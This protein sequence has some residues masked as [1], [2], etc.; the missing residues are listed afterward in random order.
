METKENNIVRIP[1]AQG[2][3]FLAEK[4]NKTK[5]D[6]DFK[7]LVQYVVNKY[8]LTGFT[9]CT[10]PVDVYQ[11]SRFMQI[12]HENF[13]ETMMNTADN[14]GFLNKDNSKKLMSM[15]S[16]LTLEFS[17]QDRARV[18]NQFELLNK[19]QG[20]SYAPFISSEV[21]KSLKLLM[22]SNAQI[23][24][25][26]NS[27]FTSNNPITNILNLIPKENEDDNDKKEYLT[28]GEAVKL[29]SE[30]LGEDKAISI[31]K[32]A[33]ALAADNLAEQYKLDLEDE[34]SA[35]IVH[36][37]DTFTDDAMIIDYKEEEHKQDKA[38]RRLK[39]F[40]PKKD[41]VTVFPK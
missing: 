2:M 38:H 29:L 36:E 8:V 19:S 15:I 14:L 16:S 39:D 24:N 30:N 27:F 28:T 23:A 22:E 31:D 13:L 35:R 20:N 11:F 4:F 18:V 10:L 41:I 6:N 40:K 12:P 32:N 17:M 1:R 21:N 5:D 37:D 25:T 33:R 34:V 9:Y 3:T 7:E 26:F